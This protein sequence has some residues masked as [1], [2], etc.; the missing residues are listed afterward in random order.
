MTWQTRTLL[1]A[2]ALLTVAPDALGKH[3]AC[4]RRKRFEDRHTSARERSPGFFINWMGMGG[5]L[6]EDGNNRLTSRRTRRLEG[7]GGILRAGAVI[8]GCHLIGGRVHA[9]FR[10]SRSVLNE[11]GM[12]TSNCW[13]LVLNGFVG[14]EY[15][16]RV[17]AGFYMGVAMGAGFTGGLDDVE[18]DC[19]RCG[20]GKD[21]NDVHHSTAF[22]AV[23][24]MGQEFRI[25]RYFALSLELFG[26]IHRG[27][28]E[29][30]RAM[31]NTLVGLAFGMG[32]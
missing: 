3:P 18:D 2:L 21:D 19:C 29:D 8:D 11:E 23:A 15:R 7:S 32:I 20:C 27:V 6:S 1:V 31:N 13:G 9:F 24:T 14:P 17:P 28:D 26:A 5:V 4:C 22:A 12:A 10:P 30:D 25:T 16:Y